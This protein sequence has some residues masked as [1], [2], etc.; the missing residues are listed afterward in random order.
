MGGTWF[1][2]RRALSG[3]PQI[4]TLGYSA[5][6]VARLREVAGS[7]TGLIIVS[8]A[9]GSGKTTLASSLMV[10]C[11]TQRGDLGICLENPPEMQLEGFYGRNGV[12]IQTHVSDND[13]A[14]AVARTLRQRPRFIMLGEILDEHAARQA[15]RAGLIGHVVI[16]TLHAGSI[17]QAIQRMVGFATE[18]DKANGA[19]ML[20]GGLLAVMHLTASGFGETP[21]ISSLLFDKEPER[22]RKYIEDDKVGQLGTEIARQRNLMAQAGRPHVHMD[23]QGRSFT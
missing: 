8:G 13:F 15:M 17:E 16:T 7:S 3:A 14:S 12:I 5:Q 23:G 11:V 1:S 4:D 20:A 18:A 6:L 10:D 22:L 19:R 2:L 9:M 21:R